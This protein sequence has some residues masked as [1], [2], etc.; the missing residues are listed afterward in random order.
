[1]VSSEESTLPYEPMSD[2]MQP[3]FSRRMVIASIERAAA[4]AANSGTAAEF[5]IQVQIK[6]P[7]SHNALTDK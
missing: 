2:E 4:D 6:V 5:Q 1:M 7:R 3:S